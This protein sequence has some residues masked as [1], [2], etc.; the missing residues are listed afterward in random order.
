M[1]GALQFGTFSGTLMLLH[2][3]GKEGPSRKEPSGLNCRVGHP[4]GAGA[5]AGVLPPKRGKNRLAWL[6]P[7]SSEMVVTMMNLSCMLGR[8]DY[9]T[10][11]VSRK[12]ARTGLI[13]IEILTLMVGREVFVTAILEFEWQVGFLSAYLHFSNG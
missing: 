4:A 2:G 10:G 7:A 6:L 1:G 11:I 8:P 12:W 5:G 9:R 3:F 13:E